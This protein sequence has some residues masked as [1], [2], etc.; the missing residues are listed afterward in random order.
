[1]NYRTSMKDISP[2]EHLC[3][4]YKTEE[5]HRNIITPF[6]CHGLEQGEKVIYVVDAHSKQE[7]LLY[8]EQEGF[9]TDNYITSGQ[10]IISDASAA[11]LSGGEF[12]P[13]RMID[14]VLPAS[15]LNLAA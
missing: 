1:M 3:F 8:L 14:R 2:G 9:S 7:I 4:M 13:D 11:H 6:I 15:V 10:L 12:D 5:E